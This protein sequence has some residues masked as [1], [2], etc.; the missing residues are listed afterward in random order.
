VTEMSKVALYGCDNQLSGEWLWFPDNFDFEV[1]AT[2]ATEH[3]IE[4][5]RQIAAALEVPL[6]SSPEAMFEGTWFDTLLVAQ[7]LEE[8]R[9]VTA[10]A[11]DRG[12]RVHCEVVPSTI[13]RSTG[14]T[15][16]LGFDRRDADALITVA[17][18]QPIKRVALADCD[19]EAGWDLADQL[20]A[21][22]HDSLEDMVDAGG[23]DVLYLALPWAAAQ[24]AIDYAS[25]RGI[26][27]VCEV[28]PEHAR[29]I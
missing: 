14:V 24:E 25:E 5:L 7:P 4:G 28:L 20:D 8:A 15:A 2:A 17:R 1:V 23:F 16:A 9:R 22:A 12:V 26:R 21:T 10:Y 19:V 11:L 29:S 18:L 3:Q 13:G 6:Y 27:V